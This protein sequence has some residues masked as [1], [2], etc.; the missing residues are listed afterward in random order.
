M[1]PEEVQPPQEAVEETLSEAAAET[2]AE[3]AAPAEAAEEVEAEEPEPAPVELSEVELKAIL[4]AVIYITEEQIGR[5][6][7]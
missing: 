6:H 4:E 2:V 7:V 5:A 3:E 1:E